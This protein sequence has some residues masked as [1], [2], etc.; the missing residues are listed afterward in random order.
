MSVSS[1]FLEKP[2]S[3]SIF[4]PSIDWTDIS[5]SMMLFQIHIIF[6]FSDQE[7]EWESFPKA[8]DCFLSELWP[9]QRM[10]WT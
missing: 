1:F 9:F 2:G 7:E 5:F 8:T 10:Y 4:I 6:V 3:V